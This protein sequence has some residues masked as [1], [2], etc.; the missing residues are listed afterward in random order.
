MNYIWEYVNKIE[1][2]EINA[3]KRLRQQYKKIIAMLD[4]PQI[5]KVPTIDGGLDEREFVFSESHANRP[6]EFIEQFCKQSKG[7]WSGQPIDLQLFQKAK[8][9]AV[10]GFVDVETGMRL[11]NESQTYESRKNGKSTESAGQGLFMMVGDNEGGSQVVCLATKKDQARIVFNEARN[12][13]AQSPELRRLIKKRKSDLYCPV[14][15]GTFEP[16][17]SDSNTLDGLNPNFANIDEAHALKDRGLYDIVKQAM[18]ARSQ[19]LLNIITTAGFVRE[20]IYDEMYDEACKILDGLD[21]FYNP[22]LMAFIYEL[23]NVDEWTDYTCWIKANPGLGTIKDF[24]TLAENVE[25][26][27]RSRA[28]LPTLLTKDFNIRQTA[29]G[30]WLTFEEI[31]IT[32]VFDTKDLRESYAVGGVDLSSTT[33]LTC[34]TLLVEKG[35]KLFVLQKYFIP[36]DVVETKI[37]EDGVPYGIWEERGLVKTCDGARVNFSDVTDWFVE[38]RDRYEI[39]PLWIGYDTWGS[40]YW[41]EEMKMN[42]FVMEPVIQGARTMS[43]P[44]KELA[45][46]FKSK[47]INYN[48]NPVLKWCMTNTQ[49]KTDENGN[50]RP[51]KGQNAKQRI[52]GAVSLIDAYVVYIKHREDYRNMEG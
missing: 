20:S 48:N 36:A 22:R 44:M 47:R 23:D 30:S 49:I 12:M 13:V 26:A 32:E 19:P 2:G 33:D 15:F 16:M 40:Q 46:E 3:G 18:Y 28:F 5:I 45:A 21:G 34:A 52:D 25:K 17:A 6:I 50:I 51:V 37:K 35:E 43:Q 31:N 42:G 9:Q 10:Y 39:I 7:R 27:K 24:A 29:T 11:C 1:K 38:M 14:N 41:T 4:G 8:F